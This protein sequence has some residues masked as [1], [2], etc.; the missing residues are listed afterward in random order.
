MQQVLVSSFL[1]KFYLKMISFRM[2]EFQPKTNTTKTQIKYKSN[3]F[4]WKIDV[5]FEK[6]NKEFV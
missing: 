1:M 6:D 2:A 4:Y 5:E 3:Q